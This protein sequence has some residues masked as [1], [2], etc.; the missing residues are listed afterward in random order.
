M[1]SY[2]KTIGSTAYQYFTSPVSTTITIPST[3]YITAISIALASG[4]P[5]WYNTGNSSRTMTF[6]CRNSNG[7]SGDNW[8]GEYDALCTITLG[9]NAT[10]YG[11]TGYKS[12]TLSAA[13]G[14]KYSGCTVYFQGWHSSGGQSSI[15]IYGKF[16][17]TIT[18]A[19]K[20]TAVVAGNLI[21]KTDL[22]QA[23]TPDDATYIKYRTKFSTGTKC[24]AST[25]NSQVL[26]IS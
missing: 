12:W 11:T 18:T 21:K 17:V 15:A 26:G 3:E 16:T 2:S 10:D 23:A 22:S 19:Y 8:A 9:A 7:G 24:E 20:Y 4:N 1:P 13:N 14:K 5:K 25:F 6:Y